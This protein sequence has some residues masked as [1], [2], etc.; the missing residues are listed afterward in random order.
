[1]CK[2]QKKKPSA[3]SQNKNFLDSTLPKLLAVKRQPQELPLD[4]DSETSESEDT[5][6]KKCK[7]PRKSDYGGLPA[8]VEPIPKIN[9]R[10]S[11]VT[12]KMKKARK[13]PPIPSTHILREKDESFIV[14][15]D[16]SHMIAHV[17]CLQRAGA[18]IS[19]PL[20]SN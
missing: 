2:T 16:I 10:K 4:Y 18:A 14:F 6:E 11:T 8:F 9:S 15:P 7:K 5:G 1:M 17:G 3:S 20:C 12:S 13:K 19:L